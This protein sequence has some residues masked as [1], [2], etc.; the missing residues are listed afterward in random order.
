[1]ARIPEQAS[2]GNSP[3]L[4]EPQPVPGGRRRADRSNL[5]LGRHE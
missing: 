5:G 2:Q 3:F 4:G 1:M